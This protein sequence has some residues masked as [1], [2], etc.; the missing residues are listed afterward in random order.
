MPERKADLAAFLSIQL[1]AATYGYID[2]AVAG[3][4]V[5]DVVHCR[6]R[7]LGD[8][9]NISKVK[10]HPIHHSRNYEMIVF[11]ATTECELT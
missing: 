4:S 2:V 3:A 1:S 6:V 9:R 5:K 8:G 7:C 11:H 10:A